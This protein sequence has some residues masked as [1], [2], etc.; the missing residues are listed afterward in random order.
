MKIVKPFVKWAGGK[1]GLLSQLNNFYPFDLENGTRYKKSKWIHLCILT[2]H[3]DRY[4]LHQDLHHILKKI[5]VL[6]QAW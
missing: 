2:H 1:G 5:V 6:P 4:L 3:I